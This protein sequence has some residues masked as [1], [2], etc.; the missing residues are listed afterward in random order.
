M[1]LDQ[2]AELYLRKREDA[3]PGSLNDKAY[4]DDD[5]LQLRATVANGL[6]STCS[7]GPGWYHEGFSLPERPN[8]PSPPT[9]E[10]LG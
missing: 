4:P 5:D 10:V 7:K 1:I 8:L 9:S 3:S 6:C 2:L